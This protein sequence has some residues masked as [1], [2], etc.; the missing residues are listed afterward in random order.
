MIRLG[1][2]PS[3]QVSMR[4]WTAVELSLLSV[5]AT[6]CTTYRIRIHQQLRYYIFRS[7]DMIRQDHSLSGIGGVGGDGLSSPNDL[8]NLS[9]PVTARPDTMIVVSKLM[10]AP[11]VVKCQKVLAKN[12]ITNKIMPMARATRFAH[13]CPSRSDKVSLMNDWNENLFI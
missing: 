6:L 4:L 8:P 10:I 7:V 12:A 9:T 2:S 1:L 5:V 3:A 13:Q 11:S